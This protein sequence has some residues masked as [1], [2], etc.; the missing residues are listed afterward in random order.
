M[1]EDKTYE[2]ILNDML[3]RVPSDVDKREGSVIYDA[4]APCAYQLA[5][6][7][8]NLNNFIDLVSGDTAVGEYLD[9][10]VVDYGLTRKPA[11]KAIRKIVTT[12]SLPIGSRWGLND[13]SYIVTGN[14]STNTYKAECEQYGELGNTYTGTLENID[15]ISGVTAT[16]TDII[17][18][19]QDKE[20]DDNLR[21]RFYAYLQ[22]PSTSGNAFNYREWALNVPGVGDAKVFPLWNGNG[23]VKILVIN[24]NMEIDETLESVVYDY[25]ETVRP[26]G[27]L[28]T[29]DS[30]E[31][32]IIG[33]TANI[34]LDGSFTF[35][36]VVSSFTASIAAYFKELTFET[37]SVS[38]AKI[39]S[40]LLSTPGIADYNSLLVDGG[41]ANTT[42]D[43]TEM[44]IVG[45]I[46]LTEV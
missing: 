13:T 8:F 32:K 12:G 31:Q 7:Y 41:T 4:L 44:P 15:N 20:A 30:P 14:I 28:V 46:T 1:F 5:K 34:T 2:N 21:A 40:I 3:E 10:V 22:R 43:E 19:G 6:T 36:D 25:I 18:S 38:Y 16:L 45:T 27:A 11:T 17:T 37:Y 42:I 26:I 29:V 9:R 39:G 35:D 24:S 23:T 33:I